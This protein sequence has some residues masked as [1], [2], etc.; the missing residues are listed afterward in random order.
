MRDVLLILPSEWKYINMSLHIASKCT[1]L[2][3]AWLGLM[4][5]VC[6]SACSGAVL[7][8]QEAGP[9]MEQSSGSHPKHLE[10]VEGEIWRHFIGSCK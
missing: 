3:N 7:A 9:E 6:F 2:Q 5:I 1:N 10:E 4:L 8:C